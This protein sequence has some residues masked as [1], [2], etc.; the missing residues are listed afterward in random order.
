MRGRVLFGSSKEV[1]LGH[2]E[3]NVESPP[4]GNGH[5]AVRRGTV[6]NT[7]EAVRWPSTLLRG[8]V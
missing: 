7:G 8:V 1:H 6:G 5:G 2:G 4:L 3:M